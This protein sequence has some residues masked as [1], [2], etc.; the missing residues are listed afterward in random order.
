MVRETYTYKTDGTIKQQ[1]FVIANRRLDY[2]TNTLKS[3]ARS[4]GFNL[5]FFLVAS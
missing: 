4:A 2:D 1:V 3:T 5:I